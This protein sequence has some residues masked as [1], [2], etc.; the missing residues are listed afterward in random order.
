MS[1]NPE[2]ESNDF[3]VF[4]TQNMI[5]MPPPGPNIRSLKVF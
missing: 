2:V 1:T 3:C 5:E 4:F